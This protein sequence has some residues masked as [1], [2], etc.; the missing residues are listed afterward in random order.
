MKKRFLSAIAASAALALTLTACAGDAGEKKAA[1]DKT[2]AIITVN[3][4]EPE[5]PL[6]PA[7][8]NEV[9]GGLILDH[10]FAGLEYYDKDGNPQMELAESITSDDNQNWTIK[11][12]G[13][14]KFSDGTPVT[15]KSFVD[16]WNQSVKHNM[17]N[18]YFFESIDG[19]KAAYDE[20]AANAENKSLPEKERIGKTDMS[21]LVVVDDKTFTV[22]LAQ[23]ESDFPLRLGYSAYYPLPEAGIGDPEKVAA[24]GEAPI[25][26]G[27]YLVKEGSWQHNVQIELV[28]NPDYKGDREPKNGGV[29]MKFYKTQDAA[30][31]DLLGNNLDVLDAVP[32]SAFGTY[33]DELGDRAVNQPSAIFQSFTIPANDE[34]FKG[35]AGLLRKQA[36]SYAVNRQEI[37]DTIFQGTR[38]P[39]SDFIAPVIPGHNENLEG[40][41]V[42]KYDATKA[43][44]LWAKADAIQPWS[45]TFEIAYNSD[46][47]HQ[48]WVD[49]TTNSIKNTLG[50][51][52]KGNPYPDFKS[53]RSE[54]TNRT[55]KTAFRTGWQAD[56]PSPFNFLGPLYGTNAS[57]NDGDYSNADFDALLKKALNTSDQTEAFKI[58]DQAQEVLLKDLP[59]I[60]L[61]YSNVNGGYGEGV[62]NVVFGWNSK[63]L[64]YQITK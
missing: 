63:A 16:A 3:N 64:L 53:L 11:L 39:A 54:V 9:G 18:A 28:P 52:A 62:N 15:A 41:E 32:D 57:S 7:N 6:V 1:G 50:I 12:K 46:G 14:S 24:Y 37:C 27:P 43:K 55:I 5:S 25:T 34:R 36:L 33:E 42:L 35:E 19:Y 30:Y 22:K 20:A 17:K 58:Y 49:A 21:G 23:P 60:P 45:G 26:N 51:D 4:T 13:D 48:A 8:T 56:Y 29:T 2:D 31:N 40:K 59:S 44:E 61:W 47:G 38:T 10:I